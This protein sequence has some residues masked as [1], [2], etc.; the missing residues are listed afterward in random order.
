MST[1]TEDLQSFFHGRDSEQEELLRLVHREP[2]TV[3]FGL[4]GLGK[5]SLLQ[6]GV[7]P[8]LRAQGWLPVP[9]RLAYAADTLPPV[10]QIKEAI[11]RS[12][13]A[14]GLSFHRLPT[15][16]E[17]LWEF[18]HSR[19]AGVF[20][21]QGSQ[22]TL[23]LAFDQFEEIFTLGRTADSTG[24]LRDELLG[25]LADLVGNRV[26]KLLSDRL[27]QDSSLIENLDFD[28]SDYRVL[29]SLREDYLAE[30]ESL[31]S[32][33]PLILQNRMRL[34][35]MDGKQ[36]MQAVL[37]PGGK[38]V[39]RE[40]AER[41]V[42]FVS[43]SRHGDPGQE[44]SDAV[45]EPLENLKVEPSLLSLFCRELNSRRIA[46]SLAE[47]TPD[48]LA[49]SS[50]RILQDFYE[51]CFDGQPPAAKDFIE[52]ELLTDTGFRE[53]MAM[54]SARKRMAAR[55]IGSPDAV[56]E[57]L[58]MRRLL[59]IEERQD[60]QRI[61]LTHDV[62][63]D[64]VMKSRIERHKKNEELEARRK[65]AERE[66]SIADARGREREALRQ[67]RNTRRRSAFFALLAFLA[68][69][70]LT[71]AIFSY[72]EAVRQGEEL[73]RQKQRETE[74]AAASRRDASVS[75]MITASTI[76]RGSL[77]RAGNIVALLS[78]AV[79]RDP[80]NRPAFVSL[81]SILGGTNWP[82]LA[83]PA[84][85]LPDSPGGASFSIDGRHI[86][87]YY[88]K[89]LGIWDAVTGGMQGLPSA[90]PAKV[91]GAKFS[92]DSKSLAIALDDGTVAM[93]EVPGT[94]GIPPRDVELCDGGITSVKFSSDH[95]FLA[96]AAGKVIHLLEIST[97]R[98]TQIKTESQPLTLQFSP[99]GT[100]I[101]AGI[102][103][104]DEGMFTCVWQTASGKEVQELTK[105][106]ALE[107]KILSF[108]PRGTSLAA[109]S[110][111]FVFLQQENGS[112]SAIKLSAGADVSCI[113]FSPD[114]TLIAI[115]SRKGEVV[116]AR[117]P[118]LAPSGAA[119]GTGERSLM[120]EIVRATWGGPVIS[121]SFSPDNMR[122]LIAIA[123][124]TVW[125]LDVA[126][127]R[128]AD[129]NIE[130]SFGPKIGR[131]GGWVK[132][133][134][135]RQS[136]EIVS[137]K[138]SPDGRK[139]L[140]ASKNNAV[141][142]WDILPNQMQPALLPSPAPVTSF[143]VA[144]AGDGKPVVGTM[145]DGSCVL[146]SLRDGQYAS[147]LLPAASSPV[148]G[149]GF[150]PAGGRVWTACLDGT[151]SLR[152]ADG[153]ADVVLPHPSRASFVSIP[154]TA[155]GDFLLTA[156][157]R[158]IRLLALAGDTKAP[159]RVFSSPEENI[160]FSEINADAS[161]LA[162]AA[163]NRVFLWDLRSPDAPVRTL[164]MK[165][166]PTLLKFVPGSTTLA[167]AAGKRVLFFDP[168]STS[169]SASLPHGED[170][171]WMRFLPDGTL[172][173]C[174]G[175][176]VW[177]WRGGSPVGDA[178]IHPSAISAADTSPE[179]DFLITASDDDT[180]RIWELDSGLLVFDRSFPGMNTPSVGFNADA[181]AFFAL[182]QGHA[183][184]WDFPGTVSSVPKEL[185]ALGFSISGTEFSGNRV[186]LAF[187]DVKQQLED[188]CT[189]ILRGE[190][191]GTQAWPLWLARIEAKNRPVS[192]SSS[193][194]REAL[195][196]MLI[197]SGTQENL[198]R[199]LLL[200]PC[201]PQAIQK[202]SAV[203]R[204]KSPP[205][206]RAPFFE[207]LAKK[208]ESQ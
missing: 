21:A 167:V 81:L 18:F 67:L 17:S 42:R 198:Q 101:A 124:G 72:R 108:S 131:T 148:V 111:E 122:A 62:L 125:L 11:V 133:Q 128:P 2:L 96:A 134:P 58:V 9:L 54:P 86:L 49:S 10:T 5:S 28:R 36:A 191:S 114:G 25:E 29:V 139:V 80:S 98:H 39:S 195:A 24:A 6:A 103:T 64:V 160:R 65:D 97:G 79:E 38:L 202:L 170:V 73:E 32:K 88:G 186:R 189:G 159:A 109:S 197:A 12:V 19:D 208:L 161:V 15:A 192:P 137:A 196:D 51:Q 23:L 52:D 127:I 156:C 201:N 68:I 61:E 138:F 165:F 183:L 180:V 53:N 110:K 119:D 142:V 69:A 188:A 166:P 206:P 190:A 40:V 141:R 50:S 185:P 76:A 78:R 31:R 44:N 123:D 37:E 1:F 147:T 184:A 22:V 85:A 102:Q 168:D 179:G 120:D 75:D 145:A 193:L 45:V 187:S 113:E 199:A 143:A 41:I 121:I 200:S 70:G 118:E 136:G 100:R 35:P 27:E 93:R 4:S 43:H 106:C 91:L 204:K 144:D 8:K 130:T 59:H 48:L 182:F 116:I 152:N 174:A 181:S 169:P 140:V 207:G 173:T 57:T 89:T 151:V 90:F 150:D 7:F 99:D 46:R 164:E 26:P 178:L 112:R 60:L 132:S 20:D 74:L 162:A 34:R 205:D 117:N 172:V 104:L 175:K 55:G 77:A 16:C 129:K 107:P 146:W 171:M 82:I 154:H 87:V 95:R 3:L 158:E 194:T 33:M 115:G 30:L 105:Q 176:E 56:I 71:V 153:A 149:A 126:E 84:I 13:H 66:A 155:Q 14:A 63:T 47:I 177:Q 94:P 163:G 203:L 83:M 92:L 157:G 135:L